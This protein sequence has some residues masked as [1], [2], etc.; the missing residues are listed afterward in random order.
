MRTVLALFS[1][2]IIVNTLFLLFLF[3]TKDSVYRMASIQVLL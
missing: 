1:R 3:I 2:F